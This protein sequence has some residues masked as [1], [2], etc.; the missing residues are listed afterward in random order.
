MM[1]LLDRIYAILRD[2]PPAYAFELSETGIAMARIGKTPELDFRPLPPGAVAVSPVRD[3]VIQPDELAIAVRTLAPPN[4]KRRDVAVI[5]PD[6][7]ARVSVL[8]FD[9]FPND[10]KE[11]LALVRFRIRKS[12]PYDVESAALSYWPQPRVAHDKNLEVV[13]AVAPLEVV[14]RYEAPFRAAGLNPGLVTTSALAA[15]RLIPAGGVAVLAKLSGRVLTIVVTADGRVRL[16]RTIELPGTTLADIGADLY[17]TFIY[18]DDNL[19]V[20]S[21]KLRLCGFGALYEDAR[22][23]F[24]RELNLEVEPLRSPLGPPGPDNAGLLGYLAS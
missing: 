8:D 7:S 15:L 2:P 19:K 3:N 14:S 5:L 10:T 11:Q 13:V 12:V 22:L 16:I 17:Q 6:Y 23:Q 9:S 4:G 21:A 1:N 24:A 18:I 20:K